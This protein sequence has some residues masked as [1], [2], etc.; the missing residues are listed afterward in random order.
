MGL[1]SGENA[2]SYLATLYYYIY[3]TTQRERD[4]SERQKNAHCNADSIPLLYLVQ[5]CARLSTLSFVSDVS[6]GLGNESGRGTF[7]CV[8]V[9]AAAAAAFL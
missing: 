5:Y 7:F 9:A 1:K 4:G 2:S 8:K 3:Y 6:I